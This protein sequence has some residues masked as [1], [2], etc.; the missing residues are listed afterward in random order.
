MVERNETPATASDLSAVTPR[1]E[2]SPGYQE[3]QSARSTA[4]ITARNGVQRAL[5]LSRPDAN[6]LLDQLGYE[7]VRQIYDMMLVTEDGPVED[8]QIVAM[9]HEAH[10]QA[11]PSTRSSAAPLLAKALPRIGP[12]AA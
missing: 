9:V 1:P 4:F 12:S 8:Q 11:E 10:R 2:Q 7:L 6:S 5:G 3:P